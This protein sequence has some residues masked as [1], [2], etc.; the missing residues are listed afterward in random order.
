MNAPSMSVM[1]R[2]LCLCLMFAGACTRDAPKAPPEQEGAAERRVEKTPRHDLGG[3]PKIRVMH[4]KQPPN[5]DGS[6]DEPAWRL[7]RS[8]GA[9][10]ETLKGG[11]SKLQASAKLL[12]DE[13][14][15]Y[16]GAAVQDSLL[17]ASQRHHDA[18]L[19]EQ[20][21]VELMIDPDGDELDY[22]EVQVSP[23]GVVFDTRFD[24]RRVPKPFGHMDWD[25]NVRVGVS[26][27]GTLDDEERD[28]G[29]VVEIAIPWQAFSLEGKPVEAPA[30]GDE[31]RANIYVLDLFEEGQRAAA[32]SPPGI[33]D[34]HVPP[35]FGILLFEGESDEMVNDLES[36]GVPR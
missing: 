9:F 29:Y 10:V 12:W 27:D 34:F 14:F 3:V 8:T 7:A 17:R 1:H 4:T 5:L 16:L 21:S 35:R 26:T 32:W 13:H 30:V 31:W 25:G 23:G 6:L 24:A 28:T 11:A 22:Y 18:H 20:D 33:G 36:V 15:L 2:A 19:W